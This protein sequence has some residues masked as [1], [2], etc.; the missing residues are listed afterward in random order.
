M[1]A[2]WG[3]FGLFQTT[4]EIERF[5]LATRLQEH[6][7]ELFWGGKDGGW[8]ATNGDDP[9]IL[10]RVKEDYDVMESSTGSIAV[11]NLMTLCN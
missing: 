2:H 6:Q 10:L 11:D 7:D 5:D 3:S 1:G 4:G 9:S 8:F